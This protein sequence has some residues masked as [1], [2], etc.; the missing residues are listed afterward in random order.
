MVLWSSYPAE[1]LG[2]KWAEVVPLC[3]QLQS[4]TFF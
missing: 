3:N 1:E 2:P 4:I